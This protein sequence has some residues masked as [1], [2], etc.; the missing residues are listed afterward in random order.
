MKTPAHR[1]DPTKS[2]TPRGKLKVAVVTVIDDLGDCTAVLAARGR[3]GADQ[4]RA[5]LAPA[6]AAGSEVS[7]DM[8]SS[9]AA[10]LSEAGAA[11][12]N[13]Y[14][15]ADAGEDEL[16][17]VN[18]LHERLRGFPLEVQGSLD[19]APAEVPVVVLLGGAGQAVGR[20][21]GG[22]AARPRGE[23]LVRVDAPGPRGGA[24]AVLGLL[25]VTG[26][27]RRIQFGLIAVFRFHPSAR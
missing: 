4:I 2:R 16:G 6:R 21:A 1:H 14:G 27:V 25:G 23:R 11:S 17:M 7:T 5:G 13:R 22:D 20:L 24:P 19:P 8:H 18:A 15:A 3:P 9:Y 26:R 10:P 12:H